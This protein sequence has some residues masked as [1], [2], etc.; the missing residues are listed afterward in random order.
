MEISIIFAF[1]SDVDII[2]SDP[3][4]V[5]YDVWFTT[6]HFKSTISEIFFV[7]K[8]GPFQGSSIHVRIYVTQKKEE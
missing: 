6:E 4:F 1:R 3:S 7:V 2:S 8:N 5:D